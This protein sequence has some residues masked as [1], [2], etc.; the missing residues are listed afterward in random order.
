MAAGDVQDRRQIGGKTDLTNGQDRLGPGCDGRLDERRID[1]VCAGLDVDKHGRRAGVADGVARRDE[2][3]C[4]ADHLVA[5]PNAGT[6]RA[7]C[8]AVVQL[9]T[10]TACSAPT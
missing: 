4:G 6:I 9:L 2:A 3:V 5:R 10:A 8:R 1:I 7:R